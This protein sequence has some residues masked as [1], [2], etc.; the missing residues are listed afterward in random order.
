MSIRLSQH[1]SR[2]RGAFKAAKA[3]TLNGTSTLDA[4]EYTET[5]NNALHING[6]RCQSI[7]VRTR[8]ASAGSISVSSPAMSCAPV[9]TCVEARDRWTPLLSSSPMRELFE[10]ILCRG[11]VSK[12]SYLAPVARRPNLSHPAMA[13]AGHRE[14]KSTGE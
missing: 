1:L 11:T 7:L 3:Q 5:T 14:S 8:M 9:S 6:R 10:P 4:H 2:V 13:L 12:G